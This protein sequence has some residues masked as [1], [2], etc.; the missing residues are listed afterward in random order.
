MTKSRFTP[1]QEKAICKAYSSG[2]LGVYA[3]A[4]KYKCGRT[5]IYIV[6]RKH[7]IKSRGGLSKAGRASVSQ[8]TKSQWLG[9]KTPPMLGKMQ[10][11]RTKRKIA[12]AL[13]GPKSPHWRGGRAY[14]GKYIYIMS[15]DHP[16]RTQQGYVAEHRLIMEKH[17]GRYL[18]P[19]EQVHHR[20]GI[21]IDNRL[22]NLEVVNRNNHY[23]Q[24]SCPHC[25][26]QFKIK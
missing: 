26:K 24:V 5:S 7:L 17:L 21:K 13:R 14:V 11:D 10:T 1:S 18:E 23:G 8:S 22:K 20:N 3:L 16:N 9:G 25:H 6:L 12:E 4:A 19:H 2:K 15:P